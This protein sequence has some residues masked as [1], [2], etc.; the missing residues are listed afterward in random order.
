MSAGGG[1]PY[2]S[3]QTNVNR[4][5]T[6]RWVEAKSFSYDGDDWGDDDDDE[7]DIEP[8]P[9]P[10]LSKKG[11]PS[12]R[13]PA[14]Y[15]PPI[16][17]PSN[18]NMG[19]PPQM[20]P[21]GRPSLDG[22]G[23]FPS[24]QGGFEGPYPT[25][26]RSP[27]PPTGNYR[28]SPSQDRMRPRGNSQPRP[29]GYE[30]HA[31]APFMPDM[32]GRGPYPMR[33]NERRSESGQRP[34]PSEIYGRQSPARQSPVPTSSRNSRDSSP[35]H[36]FPPRKSS[37]SQQQ[38][39]FASGDVPTVDSTDTATDDSIDAPAKPL[40][41]VRPA[42]IY[43]RVEEERQRRAS[44]E[45]SRPSMDSERIRSS[46][47]PPVPS[48]DQSDSNERVPRAKPT[49]DPVTERKSEYGFDRMLEN[50]QE[51]H[52][53]EP[54]STAEPSSAVSQTYAS[55][56]YSDRDPISASS[57][58]S[59][60]SFTPGRDRAMQ[61]TTIEKDQPTPRGS[62]F[63]Q[64]QKSDLKHSQSLGYRSL[65]EKAFEDSEEQVPP[66][67]QSIGDSVPR[68]NS[69]STSQISPII[70]RNPSTIAQ[71]L[72]STGQAEAPPTIPEESNSRPSTSGTEKD[73][74][75]L[76]P[77]IRP[78]YRRETSTP[79]PNNSPARRPLSV[80]T[81]EIPESELATLSTDNERSLGSSRIPRSESPT[82]GKVRDIAG[83]FNG[84][85]QSS[86]SAS[87]Q[88]ESPRPITARN[89][90]F[91][92]V[93]PGGWMSYTTNTGSSTP[94]VET[95]TAKNT[96]LPPNQRE[97]SESPPTATAPKQ[98]ANDGL[99]GSAFAAAA[100]AGSALAGAFTKATEPESKPTQQ[101]N[102]QVKGQ[103]EM[104]A[105]STASSKPPTPPPKDAEEM[106]S[107]ADD[108]FP[109]PLAPRKSGEYGSTPRRPQ[110][111]P[112]LS[113]DT[114]PQDDENDRLRKEILKD[115]TPRS[116]LSNEYQ[117]NLTATP[118]PR[119][120]V[121]ST[122]IPE[123]YNTYWN[124]V[125]QSPDLSLSKP[126]KASLPPE[127]QARPPPVQNQP[128]P[129][130]LKKRFS[131]E[132][133][134][135]D[136]DVP[137]VQP[138]STPTKEVQQL[139]PEP[140][141]TPTEVAKPDERY[142]AYS[143][144][145]VE[146]PV[147]A[148]EPSD[149]PDIPAHEVA[150]HLAPYEHPESEP[151]P[152][153]DVQQTDESEAEV[154]PIPQPI[155]QS[156][157]IPQPFSK[158]PSDVPRISQESSATK[159]L[160]FKEIMSLQTSHDRIAAFNNVRQQLIHTDT[161]LTGWIQSTS[162]KQPEHADIIN[163]NGRAQRPAI[164]HKPSP[165]R[166]KFPRITSLG[167]VTQPSQD[168]QDSVTPQRDVSDSY[169][170]KLSSH[171]M[172]EEG[173]KL[174]HS[175]G[176]IGGKAGGAA[177]GLLMKGKNRLR[178]SGGGEKARSRSQQY[179][180]TRD[181]SHSSTNATHVNPYVP[182]IRHPEEHQAGSS[183]IT[184]EDNGALPGLKDEVL[185]NRDR[186][187]VRNGSLESGNLEYGAL[188]V[189]RTSPERHG[190]PTGSLHHNELLTNLNQDAV[191]AAAPDSRMQDSGKWERQSIDISKSRPRP[192]DIEG[193]RAH[194][195]LSPQDH[196]TS[197]TAEKSGNV[198]SS[199]TRDLRRDP[200]R[201]SG[202]LSP[203]SL[204]Q[205][206]KSP[207]ISVMSNDAPP[208][209]TQSTN[210]SVSPPVS[211]RTANQ[212]P[213]KLPQPQQINSTLSNVTTRSD[214]S[215]P[216]AP[217]AQPGDHLREEALES[218]PPSHK[219]QNGYSRRT[220]MKSLES[221]RQSYDYSEKRQSNDYSSMYVG[222]SGE[223]TLAQNM[224][225]TMPKHPSAS[226]TA[227]PLPDRRQRQSY[228]RPFKE[229]DA[230]EHP[231]FRRSPEDVQ[232]RSQVYA[233]EEVDDQSRAQQQD[234]SVYRIPGPYVQQYRSPRQ[235]RPTQQFPDRDHDAYGDFRRSI[236]YDRDPQNQVRPP[237]QE[238]PLIPRPDATEYALPGVGPPS[239]PPPSPPKSRPRSGIFGRARSRSRQRVVHDD[240][241]DTVENLFREDKVKKERRS[242]LFGKRT[243]KAVPTEQP[244][245]EHD[246]M[247]NS[248]RKIKKLQRA[249]TSETSQKKGLARLSGIFSR[250]KST[251]QPTPKRN[252]MPAI[253]SPP[254]EPVN[255]GD[256]GIV[257]SPTTI[258]RNETSPNAKPY[259]YYAVYSENR[260]PRN[261]EPR[262]RQQ[263]FSNENRGRFDIDNY[264][265]PPT[266]P[267][268]RID[269]TS[270]KHRTVPAPRHAPTRSSPYETMSPTAT[271]P[272]GYGT[273]RGLNSSSLSHAIDLHKR[274]HSPRGGRQNS[275]EDL[276][277]DPAYQLGRFDSPKERQGE[278][279][280][281]W[282]IRLPDDRRGQRPAR[283]S[284]LAASHHM[285]A[286]G[287]LAELQGSRVKGDESEEEIVMSSTAYPGQEWIP[288]NIGSDH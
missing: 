148:R 124:D 43:K 240:A 144:P 233:T 23:S 100:A 168:K 69:A 35:G 53:T 56:Q 212:A 206:P 38:A 172:Q 82:K 246:M 77:P 73:A 272:Y 108:Y 126:G 9:Q 11:A 232:R 12:G 24:H 200:S 65:V 245:S 50:A 8:D 71:N 57:V 243:S 88:K 270:N 68:S 80:E 99:S 28:Q 219:I 78:G 280:Q 105:M 120:Q 5:K 48:L 192:S 269:T 40:P 284:S 199:P 204:S 142:E 260:E 282:K 46:P 235:S 263:S 32:R 132:T 226:Q 49:L 58:Q 146:S 225:Q 54:E 135:D 127:I 60:Q 196:S 281:P 119:D 275:E 21:R 185:T 51:D 154:Q 286:R 210:R 205:A 2:P 208:S 258:R 44:Q 256:Q 83:R 157:P 125:T 241:S 267:N 87:P 175:A 18:P 25:A 193:L 97:R 6:K 106:T 149:L 230:N 202:L 271:S 10:P 197:G 22:R 229:P 143:S 177:K 14:P 236:P 47:P 224:D 257:Q 140:E 222:P 109:T 268:L 26:Q 95:P 98:K 33:P 259:G 150:D 59:K 184:P 203:S 91:R 42:D 66:T 30:P 118:K 121:E 288:Q 101:S 133:W 74:E 213:S 70:S 277:A 266:L 63:P 274:S 16:G 15:G 17:P 174:L 187:G 114:S 55:S 161:G 194:D 115:L 86:P 93:L 221:K 242:S 220:S 159:I 103:P 94:A 251:N 29:M 136:D 3:F 67:P 247:E 264:R 167:G 217:A 141:L 253:S 76:N 4:T 228:S 215:V 104:S 209:P 169:G 134:S 45:S 111:L 153:P 137:A 138:L 52:P 139:E 223:G 183:K 152:S 102:L 211:L 182:E 170:S 249:S 164:G 20:H 85:N 1:G 90:S 254:R 239:P 231:A 262:S 110:M 166:S 191:S 158:L 112:Q 37:L 190:R 207:A 61:G 147:H 75:A 84:S 145:H 7:G 227:P 13:S 72:S 218:P 123:E 261:R 19:N 180:E 31:H 201:Q 188:A 113:T 279:E 39:P 171:Q 178:Q 273:A 117:G 252:T 131:W 96:S 237:S 156:Q 130:S 265:S 248:G 107:T 62:T 27:F 198:Y 129:K 116:N 81:G 173:K 250:S 189:R 162:D 244:I 238:R 234:D 64:P 36:R 92:P 181:F 276:S 283:N 179:S 285:H 151:S 216:E 214:I 287:Q 89:E 186:D 155:P 255:I 195:E 176:K 122:L 34:N 41:F 163:K 160:A 79:S 128:K 278:Q 165:S